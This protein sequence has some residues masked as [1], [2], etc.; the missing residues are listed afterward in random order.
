V[1]TVTLSFVSGNV[2]KKDINLWPL[3]APVPYLH[4]RSR[5]RNQ[6]RYCLSPLYLCNLPA[7]FER[8]HRNE[9]DSAHEKSS[10]SC[11]SLY[12]DK[13]KQ[14]ERSSFRPEVARPRHR[15][16]SKTFTVILSP[17]MS[18]VLKKTNLGF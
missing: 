4:H 14:G 15:M 12:Q 13:V 8:W 3:E 7:Q 17:K 16:S 10:C 9:R 1:D 2:S 18:G 11:P 6:A 5:Y